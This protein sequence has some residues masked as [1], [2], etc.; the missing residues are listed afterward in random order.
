MNLYLGFI[1]VNWKIGYEDFLNRLRD[2]ASWF[3][4]FCYSSLGNRGWTGSPKDLSACTVA[5]G[6]P[7]PYTPRAGR[8]NLHREQKKVRPGYLDATG[9]KTNVI[10]GLI[11]RYRY[12]STFYEGKADGGAYEERVGWVGGSEGLV[13]CGSERRGASTALLF[14]LVLFTQRRSW[15]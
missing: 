8:D 11:H 5:T 3:G 2:G 1:H 12:R 7:T 9:E 4:D 15:K 6:G 13:K 10:E 14:Y